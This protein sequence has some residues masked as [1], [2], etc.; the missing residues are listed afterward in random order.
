MTT[1]S[2]M[3]GNCGAVQSIDPDATES[4]P[5]TKNWPRM[6][7]VN[8]TG[9]GCITPSQLNPFRDEK[10]AR[11]WLRQWRRKRVPGLTDAPKRRCLLQL[12]LRVRLHSNR[13]TLCTIPLR[14]L[15]GS[16]A[17]AA[18]SFRFERP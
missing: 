5:R 7:F 16:G 11:E 6:G 17:G 10:L 8:G 1:G 3:G 9:D 13:R 2:P 12:C 14:A 4:F 18:V 15:P